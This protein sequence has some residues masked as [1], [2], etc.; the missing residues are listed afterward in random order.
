MALLREYTHAAVVKIQCDVINSALPNRLRRN[1]AELDD[2][3]GWR[4]AAGGI[5]ADEFAGL[6]LQ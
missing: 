4:R 6:E 5:G 2:R 1:G 3:V